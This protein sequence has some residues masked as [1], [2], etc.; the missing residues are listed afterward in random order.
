[1][2]NRRIIA[3]TETIKMHLFV[4]LF[5]CFLFGSQTYSQYYQFSMFFQE[6]SHLCSLMHVFPEHL[7]CSACTLDFLSHSFYRPWHQ[8]LLD[9]TIY[10]PRFVFL[11]NIS[12]FLR[13]QVMMICRFI[14]FLLFSMIFGT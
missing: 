13:M 5:V 1:M 10:F 9:F 3:G 14:Y 7:F 8:D 4:C 12:L 2:T 11:R 6:R